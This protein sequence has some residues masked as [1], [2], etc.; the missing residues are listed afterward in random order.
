MTLE[1]VFEVEVCSLHLSL[2]TFFLRA[3][4]FIFIR[5]ANADFDSW[6]L[7]SKPQTVKQNVDWISDYADH[8][9]KEGL[10]IIHDGNSVLSLFIYFLVYSRHET[11]EVAKRSNKRDDYSAAVSSNF[12]SGSRCIKYVF[13]Y[14]SDRA[15]RYKSERP[16]FFE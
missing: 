10:P 15:V 8:C 13:S 5:Y 2:L 4:L 1:F 6:V 7:S 3:T 16:Q 12:S 9:L 11:P 14:C